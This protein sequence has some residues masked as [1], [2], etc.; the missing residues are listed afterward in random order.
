MAHVVYKHFH[1]SPLPPSGAFPV[2]VESWLYDN[3]QALKSAMLNVA[4]FDAPSTIVNTAV[5]TEVWRIEF[6][7]NELHANSGLI[8]DLIGAY[9]NASASDNFTVYIKIDDV[10]VHSIARVDGNL[11]D[12]GLSLRYNITIG[13][14]GVNGELY[15]SAFVFDNGN[16]YSVSEALPHAFDTTIA[17]TISIS[18][19]WNN[20]K[21]GNTMTFNQGFIQSVHV[22]GT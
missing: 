16:T 18:F 10:L 15:D 6:A 7:A 22:P 13:N 1:V 4:L 9:S 19:K 17:H 14:E 3:F 20:A 12:V 11:T 8:V 21:A 2:E 5:E